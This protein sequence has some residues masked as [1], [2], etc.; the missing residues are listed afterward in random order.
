[1]RYTKAAL[2]A[3]KARVV[4]LRATGPVNLKTCND[5]RHQKALEFRDR[6]RTVLDGMVAQ[7][8]TRRAMVEPL[9]DLGIKAPMGG[10][11]SLGQLQRLARLQGSA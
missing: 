10:G 5:Q 3:A 1:M 8:L 11:W 6:L 7:G 9:N 2:A 4:V